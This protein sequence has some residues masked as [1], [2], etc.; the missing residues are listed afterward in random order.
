MLPQV[1]VC[2]PG[3][4]SKTKIFKDLIYIFL[5]KNSSPMSPNPTPRNHDS[6]KI[7]SALHEDVSTHIS[8]VLANYFLRK[9]F[10]LYMFIYSPIKQ[11]NV[12]KTTTNKQTKATRC[13]H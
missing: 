11:D 2:L 3:F 12:K 10:S 9:R 8:A 1:S 4:V 5:L 13:C 6:N 7:E